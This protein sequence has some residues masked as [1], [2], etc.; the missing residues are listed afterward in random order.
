MDV[1]LIKSPNGSLI[2]MGEPE[3]ES[4]KKIKSGD[5]VKCKVV[6]MRNPQFHRKGFSLLHLCYDKFCEGLVEAEYKGVK[7]KASFD[8]WRE[9]FVILAGHYDVTFNVR[10]EL[11]LKAKSLSFANCEEHEFEKIYSDLINCALRH[12]YDASMSE[13]QLRNLVDQIMAYS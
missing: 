3:A 6:R 4:L 11:K 13:Q 2:P 8:T 9:G 10:G 5:V 1:M 7:A 12:T